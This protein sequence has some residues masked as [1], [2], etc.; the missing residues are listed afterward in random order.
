MASTSMLRTSSGCTQC[1][2]LPTPHPLAVGVMKLVASSLRQSGVQVPLIG[3]TPYGAVA[4]RHLLDDAQDTHITLPHIA[5]TPDEASLNSHHT[6]F[7]LV[8]SKNEMKAAWG[9]EI[10]TRVALEGFYLKRRNVPMVLLVVQGGPGTLSTVLATAEKNSPIVVVAGSGGAASAIKHFIDK[11]RELEERHADKDEWPDPMWPTSDG[12]FE[13]LSQKFNDQKLVNGITESLQ[14]IYTLNKQ[15]GNKLITMYEVNADGVLSSSEDLSNVLLQAIV[16]LWVTGGSSRETELDDSLPPTD[17]GSSPSPRHGSADGSTSRVCSSHGERTHSRRRNRAI[18]LAVKWDRREVVA[19]L[20]SEV[21]GNQKGSD[22]TPSHQDALQ[23]ALELRRAS[24]IELLLSYPGFTL[25]K[26]NLCRLFLHD[27]PYRFLAGDESL[28]NRLMTSMHLIRTSSRSDRF[29]VFQE[30]VGKW[31]EEKVSADLAHAVLHAQ[32]PEFNHLV[33]W[34]HFFG[35][36]ELADLFWKECDDP[37]R[38][39]LLGARQC[40]LM[41]QKLLTARAQVSYPA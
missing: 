13:P 6:H 23:Y 9:N 25:E 21:E 34:A 26:V 39:A 18:Q 5:P 1:C 14:K 17:E 7:I 28:Q 20:F 19:S 27:D 40:Q 8:E 2:P 12:K 10:N 33:M 11:R 32:K 37:A 41:G 35:E 24:I 29:V 30:T 3:V 4:N 16:R 36:F 15:S 31:L 22:F 38:V